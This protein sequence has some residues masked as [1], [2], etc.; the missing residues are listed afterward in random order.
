MEEIDR[1]VRWPRQNATNGEIMISDIFCNGLAM[2]D[3]GY[4]Y[5]S[6][7]LKNEVRQWEIGVTNR[8]IL[9]AGGNGAGNRSGQFIQPT[10]SLC[11]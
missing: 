11:R 1:I 10:V 6:D 5:V 7:W 9:V 2:D 3:K 4:F 8:S